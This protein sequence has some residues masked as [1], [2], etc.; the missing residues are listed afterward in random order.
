VYKLH[1]TPTEQ[2]WGYK[3]EWKLRLGVSEQ[4]RL[5]TTVLRDGNQSLSPDIK[6][7]GA[8]EFLLLEAVT[9][10]NSEDRD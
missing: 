3:D 9:K 6:R 8:E 5:N 7:S 4:E 1:Y 2:L 10:Q